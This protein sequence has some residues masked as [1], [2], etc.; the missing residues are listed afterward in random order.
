M[1]ANF[2]I[3]MHRN[4]E[5][6]HLKLMG[7]FDGSSACEVLNVLRENSKDPLRIFIHTNCLKNVHPFGREVFRKNLSEVEG[8]QTFITFTGEKAG[9]IAPEK[10]IASHR[11]PFRIA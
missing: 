10:G 8:H 6:L 1:S 7:D 11:A 4:S 2:R 9:Q 3:S 5:N